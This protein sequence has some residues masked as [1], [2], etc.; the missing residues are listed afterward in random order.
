MLDQDALAA[1]QRFGGQD[2]TTSLA[3][4]EQSIRGVTREALE[5]ALRTTTSRDTFDAASRLKLLVGQLNVVIHAAGILSCLPHLLEPGEVIE[6]VSLGAGNTG[7]RFD[8]ETDR[9]VAEFKF[10]RWQGGPE[11]IRQNGLFK[12]FY[13]LAE[14][15]TM[16][17]KYL[18]VL[19][20][21]YPLKFM[22]SGRSLDSVLSRDDRLKQGFL[23]RYGGNC[24]VVRDY[25]LLRR[26]Q[27]SI[28]DVSQW[29]P[30]LSSEAEASTG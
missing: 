7:R 6:Y 30:A 11:A 12:D 15:E 25:Y 17:R 16:K 5:D 23:N 19:G 29:L 13:L 20:T 24:R 22:N 1:L 9:R 4:I 14:Y 26:D 10:I 3:R 18:Y 27:V 2:L 21:T 28:E 8:L